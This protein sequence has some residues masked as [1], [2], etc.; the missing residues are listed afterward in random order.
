MTSEAM[1]SAAEPLVERPKPRLDNIDLLRAIAIVMVLIYHYT[2]RY[3]GDF[4]GYKAK[5][6]CS[7]TAS[8][9]FIPF[10]AS[11]RNAW[12]RRSTPPS[13]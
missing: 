12:L 3:S 1:T 13:R 7:S 9:G 11:Q 4:Y 6:S 2:A 5:S 8:L 10:V